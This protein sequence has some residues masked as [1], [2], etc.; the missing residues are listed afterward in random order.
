MCFL[1]YCYNPVGWIQLLCPCYRWRHWRSERLGNLLEM[2]QLVIGTVRLKHW[3]SSE[4]H[5]SSHCTLIPT[6]SQKCYVW[7]IQCGSMEGLV[8]CVRG[9][10]SR[11]PTSFSTVC[12]S[13]LS[14][15]TL[16]RGSVLSFDD[17]ALSI[18]LFSLVG[19]LHVSNTSTPLV[20]E[21]FKFSSFPPELMWALQRDKV[22]C[23]GYPSL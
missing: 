12:H 15:S 20:N 19:T 10:S 22:T 14:P 4:G 2:T 9:N 8:N 18:D 13:L 16:K 23:G 6:R 1:I 5:V 17:P 7:T 11:K 21:L 3:L